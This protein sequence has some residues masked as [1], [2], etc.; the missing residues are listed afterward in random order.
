[1]NQKTPVEATVLGQKVEYPSSYSPQILVA[2]PRQL[3]RQ[4]YD[5]LD[6]QLPFTGGDVWHAWEAGFMT[7]KGMPVCGVL[8]IIYPAA[9]KCIVESKSL[10]L[11]LNS[12]NMERMGETINDGIQQY[13]KTVRD[14][15]EK[16]LD[17]RVQVNFFVNKPSHAPYDFHGFKVL[18]TMPGVENIEFSH[19]T[20][21][22]E[23]LKTGMERPSETRVVTHL[24]RSNCKITHQPDWGS[25]FIFMKS[26]V[27]P[28]LMSILQYIVSFRNENHFHEEICEMLYKRLMDTYSPELLMVTCIYTRRGGIDI[29]PIRV[30][31]PN[32]TPMMLGSIG[33]LSDKLLRQ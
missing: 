30:S 32:L 28:D 7:L 12:F 9:S 13:V 23:L 27:A 17:T 19:F 25:A 15:L 2:V 18:E 26:E 24:L 10:K 16:L 4:Q 14:D 20:D 21:S 1:M 5:I 6:N 29:C 8:K 3:N 33:M 22:P 11:Y 31:Q